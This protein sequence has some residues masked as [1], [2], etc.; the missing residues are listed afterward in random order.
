MNPCSGFLSQGARVRPG[1]FRHAGAGQHAGQFPDPGFIVQA[2]DG[3]VLLRVLLDEQV[4]IAER[5]HLGRVGHADDLGTPAEATQQAADHVRGRPA[6][7]DIG[8][9][10]HQAGQ[11]GPLGGDDLDGQADARP[12]TAGS[13][14]LQARRRVF[15]IRGHQELDGLEA[16]FRIR[17]VEAYAQPPTPDAQ[18]THAGTHLVG[19]T[20]SGGAALATHLARNPL[21]LGPVSLRLPIGHFEVVPAGA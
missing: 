15:R 17:I 12:L 18:R 1:F 3:Y 19:E 6:H 9:I 13:D 10:E 7:A 2:M 21:V 14:F 4:R 16:V 11:P 5:G 8:L 20:R